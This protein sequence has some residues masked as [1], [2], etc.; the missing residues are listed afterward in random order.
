MKMH[1]DEPDLDKNIAARLVAENFPEYTDLPVVAVQPWGTDHAL[2]RLGE[3]LAI[4]LP[5]VE[6][7][8]MQVGKEHKWLPRLA[9]HLP[10]RIPAPLKRGRPS[11]TYRWDWSIYDWI[12][13]EALSPQSD[14]DSHQ[15]ALDLAGFVGALER[16]PASDGPVAG[17]QN[18]G[19]GLPLNARDQA[20]RK[21]IAALH[22][23][24]DA[25]AA[26]AAWNAALE[27]PAWPSPPVWVHGDLQASNL[28]MRDGRL[29]AV[30]DFGGLGVGDPACDMMIAWS[31]FSGAARD[32]YRRATAVDDATWARGRGWALSVALV[33]LPYYQNTNPSVTDTARRAIH[34]VLDDFEKGIA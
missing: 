9:P 3:N 21:A 1:P 19:R 11:Q 25:G 33:A 4:R 18:F 5:R 15:L 20:T 23:V 34:E 12:K 31:L 30:L 29:H 10:C 14:F 27:V 32:A 13:G 6:R 2:F 22:G 26:T 17:S 24:I 7:A 28:L 8:V 16:I